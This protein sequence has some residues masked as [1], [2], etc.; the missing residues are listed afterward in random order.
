[1]CVV[2][3]Y[4]E[5]VIDYHYQ[6]L[7]IWYQR[8]RLHNPK[9]VQCNRLP[10]PVIDYSSNTTTWNTNN[11][12]VINY[13]PPRN[14]LTGEFA[15]IFSRLVIDY[16][17][18]V[19]DYNSTTTHWNLFFSFVIDYRNP[20]IDYTTIRN[21]WNVIFNVVIDYTNLVIDYDS[22]STIKTTFSLSAAAS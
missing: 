21:P 20:V 14:R 16:I 12:F 4:H 3:D 2:I 18:S 17:N 9:F 1:M 6:N 15:K 19:I 7:D 5:S 8:N 11:T 22:S 10:K 13:D